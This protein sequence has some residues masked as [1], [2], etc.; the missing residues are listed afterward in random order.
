[1]NAKQADVE[2]ILKLYE[3]RR[4]P[5]LRE[6]HDWYVTKFQPESANQIVRAID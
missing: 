2:L 3:L 4:D 1:L 5:R 6:A